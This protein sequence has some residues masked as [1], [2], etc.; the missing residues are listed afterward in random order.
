MLRILL[1]LVDLFFRCFWSM[2]C[3]VPAA[4]RRL[5]WWHCQSLAWWRR[6]HSCK[7]FAVVRCEA[8]QVPLCF[9][10]RVLPQ[11]LMSRVS[12][13]LNQTWWT[14]CRLVTARCLG[15]AKS[16]RAICGASALCQ[17]PHPCPSYCRLS[18]GDT[19]YSFALVVSDDVHPGEQHHFGKKA[20]WTRH[21][22]RDET[23]RHRITLSTA[24]QS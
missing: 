5:T 20:A 15:H 13:R 4:S 18:G 2:R 12:C 3:S 17:P 1:F 14:W 19:H 22:H 24:D 6:P 16:G 7:F 9:C 11:R 23:R 8:D 10:C 21:R